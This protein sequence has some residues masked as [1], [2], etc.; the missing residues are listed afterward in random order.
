MII[1]DETQQVLQDWI[2]Y[3]NHMSARFYALAYERAFSKACD[4]LDL[5]S[6][7]I[8]LTNQSIFTAEQHV[9][10][11]RELL[12]GDP[13]R[14]T[15]QLV[16][17]SEKSCLFFQAMFNAEKDYLASTCEQ[18][19]LFVDVKTRCAIK[20]LPQIA[21]KLTRLVVMDGV[22]PAPTDLGRKITLGR[23]VNDHH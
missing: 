10:F 20:I 16:E 8:S 23:H 11:R 18:L 13:L 14:I 5:G 17:I 19:V 21:R 22:F 15:T 1:V 6:A 3:N 7:F 4:S 9:T 2:D 12:V